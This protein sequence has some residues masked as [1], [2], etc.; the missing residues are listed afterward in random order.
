LREPGASEWAQRAT[1]PFQF[2]DFVLD[3]ERELRRAECSSSRRFDLINY[4]I[5]NRDHVTRDN[6]LDAVWNGRRFGIDAREP[7]QRGPS[8]FERQR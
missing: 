6:L 2:E 5:R 1:L 8:R 4:L 3:P 7:D